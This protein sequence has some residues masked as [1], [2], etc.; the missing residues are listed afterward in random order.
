VTLGGSCL[1]A[2]A[3]VTLGGAAATVTSV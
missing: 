3:A 2:G 1:A